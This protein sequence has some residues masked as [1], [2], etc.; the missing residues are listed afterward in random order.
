M[1]FE[2]VKIGVLGYG[3]FI[4]T[5]LIKKLRQC[6]ELQIV[7]IYN[8][9]EERRKQAEDD[10]FWATGDLD[11]LLARPG[12]EAVL[13]GT[14][15]DAHREHAIAC[16]AAGKHILCEKPLAL[17]LQ[18]M[19]DM[20]A[21][22]DKAG[23]ITHVN[24]G[25]VYTRA[26]TEFQ[27]LVKERC[28]RIIQVWLRSSRQFGSWK[29]GARHFAVENPESSGGWTVHHFCHYLNMACELVDS[30]V[31]KVYHVL[32]KSTPE[33]PSE[34]LC[35]SMI[36]FADGTLAQICDGTSI[37][38]F[39][40]MGVIGTDADVRLLNKEITLVTHGKTDPTGRP[41]NL[42]QVIEKVSVTSM[43]KELDALGRM[44]AEAVRNKT[45]KGLLTFRQVR[46]Q[47]KVID[48]LLQSARSG[49]VVAVEA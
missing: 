18:A 36:H 20:I 29:M 26:F 15:N 43:G 27:S 11:A 35:T 3:H 23:V 45:E 42:S 47:Y 4:R 10:G 13:I 9:G 33:A 24:H 17:S 19:D 31:T 28:G 2:P 22:T 44:F 1:A 48:A 30:P 41:G 5:N 25:G 34:E 12:M 39:S 8:R 21:A 46:N 37:G 6:P 16:A 38:G 32:Q 7:G 49:Q 14:A 40:D